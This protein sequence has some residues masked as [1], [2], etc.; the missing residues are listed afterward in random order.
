MECRL[1]CLQL[2][3]QYKMD[4]FSEAEGL[5]GQAVLRLGVNE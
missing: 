5:R 4:W 2:L 1:A 3:E